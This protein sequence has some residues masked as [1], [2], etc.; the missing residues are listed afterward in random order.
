MLDSDK[1]SNNWKEKINK[2]N[3]KTKYRWNKESED[4]REYEDEDKENRE[5]ETEEDD[6]EDNIEDNDVQDEGSTK[7]SGDRPEEQERSGQNKPC[8][9]KP[10]RVL[11]Y[12]SRKLIKQLTK[13]LKTSVDGTFKSSCKIWGQ[14]FIWMVKQR[15]Y[16]VP[17]CGGWLPDKT[18]ISYKVFFLLIME[19]LE[20]E[21]L[22]IDINSVTSDFELN[23]LKAVDGMLQVDIEGCFFHLKK[24]FQDKVIARK[25]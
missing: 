8:N 7:K 16:W 23:I 25:E 20:N 22:K 19:A 3:L 1:L 18:D 4:L 5:T 24:V 21:G 15:S 12:T 10:K 9:I 2:I 14:S 17:V 13:N 11:V 6:I